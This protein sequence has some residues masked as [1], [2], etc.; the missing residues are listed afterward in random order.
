MKRLGGES[1]VILKKKNIYI[2]SCLFSLTSHP[3]LLNS[4]PRDISKRNCVLRVSASTNP[5]NQ[6]LPVS[7]LNCQTNSLGFNYT[8]VEEHVDY[9]LNATSLW[10]SE[11][12]ETCSFPTSE[13]GD[14]AM[15]ILV[16]TTSDVEFQHKCISSHCQINTARSWRLALLVKNNMILGSPFDIRYHNDIF[17]KLENRL[18]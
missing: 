6:F 7:V 12:K 5:I 13:E 11:H 18:S 4:F 8:S 10:F 17:L 1:G 3:H 2:L 14:I 9:L 15:W 16:S